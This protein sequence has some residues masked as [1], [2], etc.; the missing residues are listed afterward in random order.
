MRRAFSSVLALAA[1]CLVV[2]GCGGGESR[3]LA[4]YCDRYRDL[5]DNNPFVALDVAS[6]GEIE[7]AVHDL[8]EAVRS[9]EAVAPDGLDRLA[10]NYAEAT[11]AVRAL[12][13]AAHYDPRNLDTGA[14]RRATISYDA[15][16]TA[17]SNETEARCAE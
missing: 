1:L 15:A 10:A 13:D 3:D 11:D 12:L 7:T 4:T 2:V 8:S 17:L 5:A 9:I 6:P 14:Y 16:A